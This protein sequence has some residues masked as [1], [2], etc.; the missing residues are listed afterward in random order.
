MEIKIINDREVVPA[1]GSWIKLDARRIPEHL[2]PSD[3]DKAAFRFPTYSAVAGSVACN[4]T[5]TGR[6]FRVREGC[7]WV[8]VQVEFVCDGDEASTFAG[9][10]MFID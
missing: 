10:W 9:G 3:W 4:V 2:L 6:G 8:R 1:V 5:V 7:R